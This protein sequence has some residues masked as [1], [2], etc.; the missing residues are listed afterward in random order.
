MGVKPEPTKFDA[1]D[2]VLLV[3]VIPSVELAAVVVPAELLPATATNNDPACL[4]ENQF[5]DGIVLLVQVT[6][7]VELAAVVV[8]T[9]A[10]KV[11][12]P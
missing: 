3:Q 9:T 4:T 1:D 10:T 7:S 11:P 8:P 5:A 6:P 2:K 12:A